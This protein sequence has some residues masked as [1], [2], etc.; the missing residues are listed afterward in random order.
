MSAMYLQNKYTRWYYK[1]ISKAKSRSLL[2]TYSEKH[3]IIPR[4]LGG[5]DVIDNIVQ[6]TAKEHFICHLLLTKMTA[7]LARRSMAYAVWK[8]T[9]IDGRDR[10][11]PSSR[12]YEYLRKNLSQSYKGIKKKSIWWKDKKHTD[13]TKEKQSEIKK[14]SKNPMWGRNHDIDSIKRI[15]ESQIGISKP[16]FFCQHCMKEIGGKANL[17]RWH[18]DNCKVLKNR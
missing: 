13:K 2:N 7:G 6:L 16:K 15:R 14:G 11:V 8:M 17:L 9:H 5:E 12:T 3:H 18:G 1:I 4:S 10:Y